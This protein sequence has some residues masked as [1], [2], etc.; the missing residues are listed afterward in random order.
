MG[1]RDPLCSLAVALSASEADD[2][3]RLGLSPMHVSDA[4]AELA[5]HLLALGA[6]LHYGG[7]LRPGGFTDLLF[8]LV[9]RYRSD[10]D[11]PMVLDPERLRQPTG[12]RAIG[13]KA[14]EDYIVNYLAWPVHTTV[15]ASKLLDWDET[16]GQIGGKL[17]CLTLRGAPLP[18]SRAA[19]A[20]RGTPS[21]SQWATGLS[22]MRRAMA[23]TGDARVVLGG[24]THGYKG[25]MPGVA[26]ETLTFLKAR[27]AVYVLGGFGGCARD[28]AAAWGLV[29]TDRTT[30]QVWDGLPELA[31]AGGEGLYNGLDARENQTLARTQS[32][33]EAAALIL[34]GLM[35]LAKAAS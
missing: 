16:I 23:R 31:R 34:R 18:V 5:R 20:P 28:I 21:N 26:E 19:H 27:K 22:S 17:V 9:A 8:E 3:E 35:R 10:A 14:A 29:E 15:P 1:N 12:S 32:I 13:P 11:F 7:D 33:D 6:R 30:A 4:A 24:R 25:R 2:L